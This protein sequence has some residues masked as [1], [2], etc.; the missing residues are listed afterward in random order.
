MIT[1]EGLNINPITTKDAWSICDFVVSNEERL[2]R[3]FP[4]TMAQNLT[5][6]LSKA[7]VEMKVL[8]FNT[9]QEFLFTIKEKD[10]NVV[11]GLV[12]L[13]NLDWDKKQGEFAYCIGYQYEGK[14]L[15]SKVVSALSTYAFDEMNMES[16][17]IITHITNTGSV[18]VAEKCGFTWVKTLPD[19]FTP[20]NESPLNMELYEQ[21][22][23]R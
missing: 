12:Y 13:K 14:G 5:P 18:K 10:S 15:T 8:L 21:Y 9:K 22:N 19:G 6:T 17:Q 3:F 16:L 2:K 20:P 11:I 1:V 4:E 7:F 23:E